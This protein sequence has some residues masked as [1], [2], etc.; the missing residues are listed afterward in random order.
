MH[1]LDNIQVQVPSAGFE[2]AEFGK[3]ECF[4]K[5]SEESVVHEF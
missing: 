3:T 1:K 4:Q 5:S 2:N